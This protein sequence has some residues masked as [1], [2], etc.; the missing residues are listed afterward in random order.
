MLWA[1]SQ[2]KSHGWE[3]RAIKNTWL[4]QQF[5]VRDAGGAC[6]ADA[7]TAAARLA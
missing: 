7:L 2:E 1:A 4:G 6:S 3:G 5:S